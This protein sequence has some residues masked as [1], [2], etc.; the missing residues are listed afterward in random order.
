MT[1]ERPE[2]RV[3]PLGGPGN[4]S[5]FAL[6]SGLQ[7][8]PLDLDK[9]VCSDLL[10]ELKRIVFFSLVGFSWGCLVLGF[11]TSSQ[12]GDAPARYFLFSSL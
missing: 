6:T 1:K 2:P 8:N 11:F 9:T 12:P 5:W 10:G 3:S 7:R 4:P